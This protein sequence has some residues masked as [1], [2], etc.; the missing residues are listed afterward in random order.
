M[1][2]GRVAAV[3]GVRETHEAIAPW[4]VEAKLPTIGAPKSDGYEGDGYV[5]VRHETTEMV[6]KLV[7][8]VLETMRVHYAG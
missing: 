8:K 7:T 6:R 5:I 3:T 1:G 2:H 4:L